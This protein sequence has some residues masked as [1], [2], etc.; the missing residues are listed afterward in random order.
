MRNGKAKAAD[1]RRK[2]ETKM[3][4]FIAADQANAAKHALYRR[5][6]NE[7]AAMPR[8]VA[9]D[10]GLFPEDAAKVAHQAVWG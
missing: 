7:F 10:L 4:S 5:T 1:Q 3:K 9:I 8:N 6:R 2:K